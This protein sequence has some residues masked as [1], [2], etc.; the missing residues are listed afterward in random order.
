MQEANA[1]QMKAWSTT[2][3]THGVYRTR[4]EAGGMPLK[5][6]SEGAVQE[7]AVDIERAVARWG[8]AVLRLALCRAGNQTDAEDIVQTVFLK[9]CQRTLPFDSDEHLKA[10]LLR[11]TLTCTSDMKRN[12]WNRHRA[13]LGNVDDVIDCAAQSCDAQTFGDAES[14]LEELTVTETVLKA[15]AS[16]SEKKR[17]AIHL[18]YYEELSTKDIAAIMGVQ[19]STVHSHLHRARA[20]LK[21]LIG[22][23]HE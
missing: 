21:E 19:L 8:D 3:P 7:A 4:E 12:P 5:K 10:W 22:E 11:V 14:I 20:S 18:Y 9:L 6:A 13:A 17:A 23:P 2:I 15:V 16:L 1:G